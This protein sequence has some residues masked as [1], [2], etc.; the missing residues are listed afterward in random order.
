MPVMNLSGMDDAGRAMGVIIVSTF[1]SFSRG[2]LKV[3]SIDPHRQPDVELRM[4]SDERDLIRMRDGFKRLFALSQHEAFT[5]IAGGILGMVTGAPIGA[6]PPDD[7]IDEWLMS[8]VSDAQ[9]PVGTCRMGALGDKRS[10]V[11]P[12]CA[13]IGARGLRVIDASV[14]P[15]NPRA[16][17]HL[18]TVM[19]AE[20]MAGELRRAAS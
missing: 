18:T 8:E 12:S 15:E 7:E 16:N 17:T 4:L 3:T 6:L 5:A 10:V 11:D 14:M 1:Q 20:K 2:N 9:H 13:V 19:I